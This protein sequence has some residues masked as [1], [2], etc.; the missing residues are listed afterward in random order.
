MLSFPCPLPSRALTSLGVKPTILSKTHETLS[1][2]PCVLPAL[3]PSS[4]PLPSVLQPHRPPHCSSHRSNSFRPQG[5]CMCC[6]PSWNAFPLASESQLSHL[7][8]R[9]PAQRGHLWPP[10]LSP[11]NTHLTFILH[12]NSIQSKSYLFVT[13]FIISSPLPWKGLCP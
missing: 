9:S 3:P 12:G 2:L 5:L 4:L 11:P 13:Q 7:S 6:F 10:K 1:D 8:F